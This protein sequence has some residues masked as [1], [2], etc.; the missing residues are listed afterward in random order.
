MAAEL[1]R[2]APHDEEPEHDHEREVEAAE[3]DRVQLGEGEEQRDHVDVEDVATIVCRVLA[4]RSEGTL[5]IA[6]G[7]VTSFRTIAEHV[8]ALSR[9]KVPISTSPRDGPMP[10]NG[11]RAFDPQNT[12]AAFADF[13]YT[14]L[15]AGLKRA[16]QQE[17][18]P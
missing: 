12:L 8:V 2:G 17:F 13:R 15:A 18:A 10:H 9:T 16:Q 4:Q 1:D 6:T 14:A 7:V 3:A 5:N 11:Y